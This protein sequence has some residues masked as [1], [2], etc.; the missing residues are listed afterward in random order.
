MAISRSEAEKMQGEH[1]LC[2]NRESAKTDWGLVKR[3]QE[4][5]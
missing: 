2:H 4:S 3:T 5:T 1:V